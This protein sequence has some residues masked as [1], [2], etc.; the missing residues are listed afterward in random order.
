MLQQNNRLVALESEKL[1]LSYLLSDEQ[2]M[3]KIIGLDIKESDFTTN[4]Y[5][6][7]FSNLLDL[8]EKN[9]K[10]DISSLIQELNQK[11]IL[12]NSV[13]YEELVDIAALI[14]TED[15]YKVHAQNIIDASKLRQLFNFLKNAQ[16]NILS[17]NFKDSNEIFDQC[18]KEILNITRNR[19][20]NHFEKASDIIS[21]VLNILESQKQNHS[22]IT[23]LATG[24]D[25]L[26]YMTNGF[27]KGNL[28]ILAARPSMG[29]T[30]FAL[31]LATNIASA[32]ST[33]AFF[34]LEMPNIDLMRRVISTRSKVNA[35]K[36][37]KAKLD[38]KDEMMIIKA[39]NS[40]SQLEFYMDDTSGIT[41][42]QIFSKCLKLK[43][44]KA[45]DAVFIDYLQLIKSSSRS[46][47][48]NRQVEVSQISRDLKQLARE[49]DVPVIALSQ[50]SRSVES[51]TDKRPMLSDLR[52]SG[53]IEQDA[54]LV[55]FLYR[56]AY[57]HRDESSGAIDDIN[58]PEETN[59]IIAKHRNGPVG[60]INLG[61]RRQTG[62]FNSV[63]R[64]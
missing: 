34:S 58:E 41:V 9:H 64:T 63:L 45:L 17:D 54:D 25:D 21:Q 57:Y 23:G 5:Q 26:D 47:G 43:N 8:Y 30:A 40:L 15:M 18:E 31:N 49:L 28:I 14:C 19:N 48:D 27:Q 16:A 33:V 51:R 46:S 32:N 13:N 61:F 38:K 1:I 6:L 11:N 12:N 7:I 37:A 24:F 29:K 53:S 36:I 3:S 2:A 50:L 56:D 44:E 39:T 4:S 52:E 59:L 10:V 60:S 55:M 22:S 35:S 62:E 20:I 42:S